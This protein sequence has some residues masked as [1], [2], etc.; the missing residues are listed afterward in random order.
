MTDKV[1]LADIA[2]HLGVSIVSVSKA[3]AGKDGVS[4]ETRK[5]IVAL[6]EE[7]DY[8]P[9]R[10]KVKKTGEE[11]SGNIGILV[12]DRFFSDNAFYTKLYRQIQMACNSCGFSAVLEIVTWE[13]ENRCVMPTIIQGNKVDGFIMMGEIQREYLKMIIRSKLPYMLLDFYDEESDSDG[14]TSDNVAGGYRLTTHLLESGKKSVGFVGSINATSSILDRFLGYTK[15]LTRKSIKIDYKWV[16]EDRDEEGNFVPVK[17]PEQLPQAFVCSCDEVAYNLVLQLKDMGY[18]VPED[19]G[20]AGYDDYYFSQMSVPQLTTYRVNYEEMG[21]MVVRQMIS[22]IRGTYIS[23]GN[24]VVK[25]DFVK[26][27]ST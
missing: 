13:A 17:L 3:L 12:A 27:E 8:V 15:A 11:I 21:N 24:I 5:K 6:A 7:W 16:L 22:R 4:E 9:L 18:R 19:I 26:R 25:G 23:H 2:E 20:V 10:T 14:I 1:R